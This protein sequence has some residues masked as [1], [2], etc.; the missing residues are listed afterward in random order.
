MRIQREY[1]GRRRFFEPQLS[2][3]D[4]AILVALHRAQIASAA[5]TPTHGA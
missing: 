4:L 1:L 5:S 3:G 2:L